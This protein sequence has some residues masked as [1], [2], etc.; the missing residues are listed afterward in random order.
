MLRSERKSYG[1][2]AFAL[3]G[4]IMVLVSTPSSAGI[5]KCTDSTGR[6]TYSDKP[7]DGQAEI[8]DPVKVGTNA[9]PGPKGNL[10][11]T[12]ALPSHPMPGIAPSS[13]PQGS[14][15]PKPEEEQRSKESKNPKAL[16]SMVE[17]KTPTSASEQ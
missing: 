8:V 17:T 14:N 10:P 4:L 7:C 11:G 2:L 13:A 1:Y 3:V 9:A 16:S 12:N 6:K 15:Q 5:Y